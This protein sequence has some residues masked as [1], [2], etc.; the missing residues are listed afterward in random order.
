MYILET[1]GNRF[2]KAEN[3][4]KTGHSLALKAGF[5][6]LVSVRYEAALGVAKGRYRGPPPLGGG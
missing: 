2:S 5:T 1:D 4:R 3:G 6:E